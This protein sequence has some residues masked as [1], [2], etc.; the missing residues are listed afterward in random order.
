MSRMITPFRLTV[1]ASVL[2]MTALTAC[3]GKESADPATAR[4]TSTGTP[5]ETPAPAS[6]TASLDPILQH[7]EVGDL[8]AAE[9]SEFSAY[10]FGG[11]NGKDAMTKAYGLL[12]VVK[13]EEDK[14]IVIT[15]N[16][17]SPNARGARNELNGELDNIGWDDAERIPIRR[18][19]FAQL[20]EQEKILEVR[21]PTGATVA[22]SEA[23]EG[24][25]DTK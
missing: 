2:A 19:R 12:R 7:P 10:N 11:Q 18:D 15:Q 6:A 13:V 14:V 8:Y 20:V 16:Q 23:S 1:A 9:L 4:S 25:N 21:R 24:S 22:A 3:G 5:R 17:A